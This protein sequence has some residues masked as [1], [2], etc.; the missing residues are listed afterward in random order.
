MNELLVEGHLEENRGHPFLGKRQ[1]QLTVGKERYLREKG[2]RSEFSPGK[3]WNRSKSAQ[4]R[5]KPQLGGDALCLGLRSLAQAWSLP[6]RRIAQSIQP[7]GRLFAHKGT[8]SFVQATGS[9][10]MVM[11]AF[12]NPKRSGLFVLFPSRY[13]LFL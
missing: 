12:H 8:I 6:G 13:T 9:H 4:E 3:K 7:V 1:I 11:R 5:L 10:M 2:T